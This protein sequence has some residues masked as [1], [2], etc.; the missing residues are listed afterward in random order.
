MQTEPTLPIELIMDGEILTDNLP[1]AKVSEEWL[2]K[3]LVRQ[4]ITDLNSVIYAAFDPREI[5]SLELIMRLLVGHQRKVG[6]LISTQTPKTVALIEI[7][8]NQPAPAK[9]YA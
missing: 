1:L 8:L 6:G 2:I 9:H 7:I 4:G 3:E 5:F